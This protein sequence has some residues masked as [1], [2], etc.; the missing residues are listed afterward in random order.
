MKRQSFY[1]FITIILS[2]FGF[3]L[4]AQK[5]MTAAEVLNKTTSLISNSK[6]VETN[7]TIYNS[8]YSG[9]GSI[10]TS[11]QKFNV[12]LPDA[13]VWYNGKD[14]YTLN[15]RTMETT[16]VSPTVEELAESNPLTYVTSVSKNYAVSFS[17]VKKEGKYVL[18]LIP[19]AKNQE[20]KRITLTINKSKFTP[21]K[22]VV[23]PRSGSPIT[24]EISSFKTG[25]DLSSILFEYPKTK[26]PK[27]EIIDLR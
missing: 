16:I 14:L 24:A 19:K 12:T 1:I 13:E 25:L 22:I 18:E 3:K 7:F 4:N 21:E 15:Q 26:F 20:I 17:T 8:G 9:S 23:E 11:G 10:K 27:V 5:A 6:G 2:L